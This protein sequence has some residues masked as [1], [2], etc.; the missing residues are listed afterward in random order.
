[1]DRDIKTNWNNSLRYNWEMRMQE[2][3][4]G[5]GY[6]LKPEGFPPLTFTPDALPNR[7]R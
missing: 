3:D 4:P 2:R 6:Q 1:M 7:G 5:M